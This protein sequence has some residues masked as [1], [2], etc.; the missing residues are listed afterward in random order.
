VSGL[1]QAVAGAA[2]ASTMPAATC[3]G[4]RPLWAAWSA[5]A[6]AWAAARPTAPKRGRGGRSRA[7]HDALVAAIHAEEAA[8]LGHLQTVTRDLERRIRVRKERGTGRLVPWTTT[9]NSSTRASSRA[10]QDWLGHRSI[11]HTVRYTEL[12]PTRFRDFWR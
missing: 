5:Y 12:T 4:R 9:I 10:I 7:Y 11:Q 2:S 6:A 1:R 3:G 8:L